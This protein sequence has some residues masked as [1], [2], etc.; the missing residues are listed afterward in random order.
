[1]RQ[2]C[3]NPRNPRWDR[4][5]GRGISVCA[6]WR[7]SFAAFL[8]DMGPHP[9]DGYSLERIDNELGYEPGNCKWATRVEQQRN[10]SPKTTL[11]VRGER[12]SLM[13]WARL[14]GIHPATLHSRLRAGWE[15][16]KAVDTPAMTREEHREAMKERERVR[17]AR[18]NGRGS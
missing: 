18:E 16:E 7:E 2:R 3:E 13:E 17:R 9:G 5:G 15:P 14:R 8:E 6:R 11:V 1:M 12:R 4:Y 10:R